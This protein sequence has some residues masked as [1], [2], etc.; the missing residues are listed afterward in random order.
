MPEHD[1][2]Q[3]LE[4][5]GATTKQ[6]ELDQASAHQIGERPEQEP[7]PRNQQDG[8]TTLRPTPTSQAANRVNAPFTHLGWPPADRVVCLF[9]KLD[10][11]LVAVHMVRELLDKGGRLP[12]LK[13]NG[14]LPRLRLC[15]RAAPDI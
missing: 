10:D 7:A 6:H 14:V 11:R 13:G 1:D 5:L 8:P 15:G 12:E 4:R 9:D 2:L 3:L